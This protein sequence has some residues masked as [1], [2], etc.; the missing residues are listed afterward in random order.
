VDGSGDAG[1]RDRSHGAWSAHARTTPAPS[2][3]RLMAT[4]RE[5]IARGA[6]ERWLIYRQI[7]MGRLIMAPQFDDGGRNAE[8]EKN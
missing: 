6:P 7:D 3:T 5:P 8:A 4:T 1:R 2:A